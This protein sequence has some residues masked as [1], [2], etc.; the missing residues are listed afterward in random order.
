VSEPHEYHGVR[1]HNDREREI[2]LELKAG[3]SLFFEDKTFKCEL[4]PSSEETDSIMSASW[5]NE[6]GQRIGVYMAFNKMF[7]RERRKSY[8]I[9]YFLNEFVRCYNNLPAEK[10]MKGVECILLNKDK[11]KGYLN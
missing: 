1:N 6:M 5:E 7:V 9:D 2:E 4:L 3:F 10:K 8:I 11:P